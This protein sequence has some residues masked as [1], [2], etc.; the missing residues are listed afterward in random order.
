MPHPL[1]QIKKH[2]VLSFSFF[3]CQHHWL[4]I[5]LTLHNKTNIV[6][7]TNKQR[8]RTLARK[9][10]RVSNVHPFSCC[11]SLIA[12]WIY[13]LSKNRDG[14]QIFKKRGRFHTCHEACSHHPI[15]TSTIFFRKTALPPFWLSQCNTNTPSHYDTSLHLFDSRDDKQQHPL[16]L[17]YSLS[18]FSLPV[19]FGISSSPSNIYSQPLVIL[20]I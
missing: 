16:T 6:A 15:H 12:F 3:P 8:T 1:K 2:I 10:L 19:T 4:I 11:N 18:L 9:L 13:S 14:C 7:L 17:L 20:I 5:K